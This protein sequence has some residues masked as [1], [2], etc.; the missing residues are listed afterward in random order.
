MLD[1]TTLS[2]VTVTVI[3][4]VKMYSN[5]HCIFYPPTALYTVLNTALYIVLH[6][7]LYTVLHT[8]LYTVLKT[9]LDIVLKTALYILLYNRVDTVLHTRLATDGYLPP[10]NALDSAG[11]GQAKNSAVTLQG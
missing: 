11:R 5:L 10:L 8:A 1:I 7:G 6:T 4:H 2:N 9:A 3:V